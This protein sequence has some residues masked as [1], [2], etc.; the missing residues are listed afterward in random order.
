MNTAYRS[1]FLAFALGV[2]KF[3][4]EGEER[5]KIHNG[6]GYC[7]CDI[8]Y[9]TLILKSAYFNWHFTYTVQFKA[10]GFCFKSTNIAQC[11]GTPNNHSTGRGQF[12]CLLSMGVTA[13]IF[14][15]SPWGH[16]CRWTCLCKWRAEGKDQTLPL[17]PPLCCCPLT[18]SLYYRKEKCGCLFCVI[19]EV[20]SSYCLC[21]NTALNNWDGSRNTRI[22]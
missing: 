21:H 18:H 10:A 5:I 20:C 16:S 8:S 14:R 9:C 12:L 15:P 13:H 1:E 17:C 6:K 19:S 2:D 11:V 3:N 4:K 7:L 22:R